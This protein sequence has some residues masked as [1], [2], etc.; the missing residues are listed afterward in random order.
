[1]MQPIEQMMSEHRLIE[2]VLSSMESYGEAVGRG[3]EVAPQ[4]L[5]DYVAFMRG[6]AEAIHHGKEEDILFSCLRHYGIP[7]EFGSVLAAV[8]RE[9]GTLSLLIDDLAS[10][11]RR[12]TP[13][14][15]DDRTRVRRKTHEYVSLLRRHIANED[16][17]VFPE[18]VKHLSNKA[19][20][21]VVKAFEDFED[22]HRA[23]R[24]EL[25]GLAERLTG[26]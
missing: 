26:V 9:H 18:A 14:S 16:D 19:M 7:E 22:E 10:A 2:N 24:E 17:Y 21:L 25:I 6:Y 4:R 20:D 1:M 13:W 3:E 11:A 8:H 23:Q 15:T 5:S 12:Q